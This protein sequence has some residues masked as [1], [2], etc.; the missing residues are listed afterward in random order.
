MCGFR[1]FEFLVLGGGPE[2]STMLKPVVR[3]RLMRVLANDI[4]LYRFAQRRLEIQMASL[5][6][7]NKI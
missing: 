2:K 5:D 7:Q 1:K 6:G 4:E 3:K